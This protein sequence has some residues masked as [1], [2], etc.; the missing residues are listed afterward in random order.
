MI[1]GQI[2]RVDV[3][4]DEGLAIA[5]DYKLSKGPTLD[6]IRSGR[7]VQIPIYLAALEQLFLPSFELGGGGYYTLRGKGAR[8]NQGLY[9]TALADCTN[10][11]S[12]WSQFD[13]LEWQSIRRDVATRVWQFIDGMRGGR[14]RVQ[15]SLGRKTCKFCDYSAVCRY[16]AYRINRKN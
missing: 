3:N 11:R 10:V 7:Q 13:D 15:P 5:Y 8:L 16:D 12:R 6:D 4:A 1:Q 2:D 9:R 14:F